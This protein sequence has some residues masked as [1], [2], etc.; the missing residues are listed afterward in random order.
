MSAPAGSPSAA[1]A[2]TGPANPDGF[3]RFTELPFHRHLGMRFSRSGPSESARVSLPPSPAL[4]DT[5]GRAA[6]PALFT[7]A[8]VAAALNTCDL[9]LP[10]VADLVAT[11][12][13]TVLTTAGTLRP[14]APGSGEIGARATLAGDF[15]TTVDRLRTTRKIEGEATVDLVDEDGTLVAQADFRLHAKLVSERQ[16]RAMAALGSRGGARAAAGGSAPASTPS[17]EP[18]ARHVRARVVEA[19]L[20]RAV[21]EQANLVELGNHMAIRHAG[22][23]YSAAHEASRALVAAATGGLADVVDVAPDRS[24]IDFTAVATG[25]ITSVA[26]PVGPGWADLAHGAEAPLSLEASVSST[27]D[28]GEPVARL[29]STW[30]VSP[31]GRAG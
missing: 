1:A 15:A 21:T 30:R 19:S 16:Y 14:L 6:A 27:N 17:A 22:A 9:L 11:Y 24:E 8:E 7:L 25:S 31:A 18:Y 10:E 26:E 13:P 4:L 20:E 3:Y 28:E 2:V 5:D 29:T 23:I 12:L